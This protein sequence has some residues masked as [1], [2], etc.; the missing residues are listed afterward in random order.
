MLAAILI[1]GNTINI[2]HHQI[3]Q[4]VADSAIQQARDVGMVQIGQNLPLGAEAQ[5]HSTRLRKSGMHQLDRNLLLVHIV[6]TGRQINSAHP[7]LT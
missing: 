2:L 1:D 4:S 3:G 6:G 5:Q 7:A